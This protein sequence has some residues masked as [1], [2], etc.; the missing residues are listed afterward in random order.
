MTDENPE[1]NSAKEAGVDP[2]TEETET[3]CE[4]ESRRKKR[5]R[6]KKDPRD[7]ALKS[8]ILQW[9]AVEQ[10]W[11][12]TVEICR[13][14]GGAKARPKLVNPLLYQMLAERSIKKRCSENGGRPMW[15][16]KSKR[17]SQPTGSNQIN[18][19]NS[20]HKRSLA[21]TNSENR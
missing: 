6:S 2:T 8:S 21:K 3:T 18:R 7:R 12:P 17:G 16:I 10:R 19:N 14:V 20:R 11:V 4:D 9:L 5:K 1:F 15:K 13:K